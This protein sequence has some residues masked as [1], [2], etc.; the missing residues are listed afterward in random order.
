MLIL[1]RHAQSQANVDG[2]LAGRSDTELTERG[3]EQARALVEA[4]RGAELLLSSPLSRARETAALAIPHLEAE[5]DEAFVEQDYGRHDGIKMSDVP[6]D[7]WRAF[8]GSHDEG[9][10]GGESTSMVDARVHARLETLFGEHVELLES[11]TRHLVVV[12]HVTPIKSAVVWALD[13]P[14]R[15]SWRLRLD[16]ASL[17]M[18][19]QRENGPYL[20]LYNDTS[21]WRDCDA[22]KR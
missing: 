18:I 20:I 5:I 3:R 12:S 6:R 8:R 14:G 1:V 7:E 17:T 15:T 4:L 13:V 16:N 2:V 10:G 11:L 22:S 9:L 19:G 21:A